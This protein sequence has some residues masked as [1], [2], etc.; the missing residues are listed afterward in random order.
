MSMLAA[1]AKALK[2][3]RG[4]GAL[5]LLPV[6]LHAGLSA[7]NQAAALQ[8]TP[9][10]HRKVT[11]G[12]S[13]YHSLAR[14]SIVFQCRLRRLDSQVMRHVCRGGRQ[15][16]VGCLL[17]VCWRKSG[18]IVSLTVAGLQVLAAAATGETGLAV[19]GV[20]FVVDSMFEVLPVLDPG[21]GLE[22]PQLVAVSR[23]A[24]ASRAALAGHL[25]AGHCFRLCTQDAFQE[26]PQQTVRFFRVLS[27]RPR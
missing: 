13:Q 16:C 14:H 24:A 19:E 1:E 26:L 7:A 9:R 11:L 27:F 20:V 23:A 5:Q 3:R 4:G 8:P 12:S 6:A 21:T 25:R 10:G 2:A 22:A 18:G 17:Y 15:V